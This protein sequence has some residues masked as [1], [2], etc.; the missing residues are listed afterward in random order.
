MQD[1]MHGGDYLRWLEERGNHGDD[2][3]ESVENFQ[4]KQ[5]DYMD[6]LGAM[7][8]LEL[9][10]SLN[11]SE[12]QEFRNNIKTSMAKLSDLSREL[13]PEDDAALRWKNPYEIATRAYWDTHYKE[14]N[15]AIGPIWDAI[16]ESKDSEETSLL[17]ENLKMEMNN[18]AQKRRTIPGMREDITFPSP[19]DVKWN[20]KTEEE[21]RAFAL[22]RAT[23]PLEWLNLD[24]VERIMS[25]APADAGSFL[26]QSKED[27]EIYSRWTIEKNRI[28]ELKE[29]GQISSSDETKMHNAI[30]EQVHTY[31][32]ERGRADEV[33]Y[34]GMLPIERLYVMGMLPP[35][36]EFV[37]PEV[38]FIKESAAAAGKKIGSTA[39]E[40]MRVALYDAIKNRA[41]TDPAFGNMLSDLGLT[42]FDE[43]SYDVIPP[44]LIEGG[45]ESDF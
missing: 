20:R 22:K 15:D 12:I 28:S 41:M 30:E 14:F 16:G 10:S 42:L 37:M 19:L 45:F 13:N 2:A 17:F 31:L 7:L 29:S 25:F 8:E 11:A 23:L 4:E 40:P 39:V 33:Q 6:T 36:L 38:R 43:G 35:E 5:R 21:K 27:M 44:K 18:W 26:P 3:Y 24:D 9:D 34:M 1:D 32:L